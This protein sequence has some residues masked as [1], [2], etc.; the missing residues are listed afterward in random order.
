MQGHIHRRNWF[1]RSLP[2]LLLDKLAER[3]ASQVRIEPSVTYANGR[4][5]RGRIE[6]GFFDN[7]DLTRILE[8]LGVDVNE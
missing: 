4:H 1:S 8:L 5:G 2:R 3:F 7:E 6:I